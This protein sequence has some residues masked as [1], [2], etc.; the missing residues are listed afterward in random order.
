[1]LFKIPPLNLQTFLFNEAS[2]IILFENP[3]NEANE[4][5]RNLVVDNCDR[6]RDIL[7]LRIRF[8]S[9]DYNRNF[10]NI[11]DDRTVLYL[12]DNKIVRSFLITEESQISTIFRFFEEY[13]NESISFLK[14]GEISIPVLSNICSLPHTPDYHIL[15]KQI[16]VMY[17]N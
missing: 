6:F 15:I 13:T 1:M 17:I 2:A 11:K 14:I 12:I 4:Y 10:I 5:I 8:H 16:N 3:L 9:K 7:F